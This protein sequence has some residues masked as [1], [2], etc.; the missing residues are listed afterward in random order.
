MRQEARQPAHERRA[1]PNLQHSPAAQPKQRTRRCPPLEA[2]TAGPSLLP[3]LV[4]RVRKA[5]P[6]APG[7]PRSS[8]FSGNTRTYILL[9]DQL[10]MSSLYRLH[11]RFVIPALP[12][13]RPHRHSLTMSSWFMITTTS[14]SAAINCDSNH[15]RRHSSSTENFMYTDARVSSSCH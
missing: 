12:F 7:P 6:P 11:D 9:H 1:Q 2:C 10:I 13:H 4:S 15:H 5:L 8:Q 3:G 14:K